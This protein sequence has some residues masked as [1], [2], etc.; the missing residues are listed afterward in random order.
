MQHAL[1]HCGVGSSTEDKIPSAQ[2]RSA[3]NGHSCVNVWGKSSSPTIALSVRW[4]EEYCVKAALGPV[5]HLPAMLPC[6]FEDHLSVASL[7][8]FHKGEQWTCHRNCPWNK[9]GAFLG[10]LKPSARPMSA[11]KTEWGINHRRPNSANSGGLILKKRKLYTFSPL[12]ARLCRFSFA[13]SQPC[14][15]SNHPANILLF[16]VCSMH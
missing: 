8:C 4:E 7:K 12:L 1:H 5:A 13:L 3:Q 14:L 9:S 16:T 11:K 10:G 6:S 15:P 2:E